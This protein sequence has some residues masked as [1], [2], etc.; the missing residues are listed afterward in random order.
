MDLATLALA[1]SNKSADTP[2]YL[3]Y[4]TSLEPRYIIVYL[5]IPSSST[6][7]SDYHNDLYLVI[8]AWIIIYVVTIDLK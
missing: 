4:S 8:V 3:V 1:R 2:I 5:Y 7:D 6:T